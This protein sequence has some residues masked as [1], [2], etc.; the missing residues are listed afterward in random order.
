MPHL[1]P[2]TPGT[3]KSVQNFK[4]TVIFGFFGQGELESKNGP[5]I[6]TRG[7]L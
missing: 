7:K 4:N 6:W 3:P 2:Q 1:C 5:Q